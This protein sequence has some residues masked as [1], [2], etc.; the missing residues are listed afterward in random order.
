[1]SQSTKAI[2]GRFEVTQCLG[3]GMQGKVYLGRDPILDRQVALKLISPAGDDLAYSENV[4]SEARIAARIS[5][6]NVI[7][8][9]EVGLYESS[10]L[11][12]FEYI[13]GITLNNYI[14]KHGRFTEKSAIN[15]MHQIADGMKCAH[16][17]SIA[18]L[19][20][21]SNNIM[22][23]K[24]GIPRIMDF[25]LA[26]VIS[27]TDVIQNSKIAMGTPRYMAPENLTGRELTQA[28][29]I[30]TLGLLFYELLT[31]TPAFNYKNMNDIIVATKNVK[32]DWGKL[33]HLA[34]SNEVIAILRDMLQLEPA[35]RY[36]SAST[37][38]SEL[39]ELIAMQ[40]HEDRGSVSLNFLLRRLQRRPEFPACSHS[41][42]EINRLT[43]ESSNTNFNQLGAV[44][45]RDYSLTN[46]I[47]K[48]ANS[49]IFDRGN[50]GVKTISQAISRLGLKLVR[51]ICNG[52]LLFNQADNKDN[53]L[54]D[55]LVASFVAGLISRHITAIKNKRLAEEAFICG[56]FHNLGN[57]LLIF[58]LPDEYD[59]IKTLIK[60]GEEAQQAERNVL[61]TTT[62]SL[63][64]AVA[65]KW[66]FPETIINCMKRLPQG[67]L[68]PPNNDNNILSH[69]ANYAN[70]LCSLIMSDTQN[71]ELIV[72]ISDFN[73][74]HQNLFK[75]DVANL[76]K[77]VASAADKFSTLAP[78]LG[79]NFN[80]SDFCQQL[81]QFSVKIETIQQQVDMEVT[82]I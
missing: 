31:G 45:I 4:I 26:H 79:V 55:V 32:I 81:S 22:M 17:Q 9:Y 78:G 14:H 25:G 13:D 21:S 53:D 50:E 70:E 30:F 57:H 33:Q 29:D 41:I 63:G 73:D 3:K 35:N 38:I 66:N 65:E 18:H 62:A 76:G 47:M 16:E 43:D 67:L 42:A 61:S 64:M 56:M 51:M 71:M 60:E 7:P 20:L 69:A 48:I 27:A 10:P 46:R 49:V 24:A 82:L 8:I 2:I 75:C 74:R 77:L 12:V 28:T 6:P 52:L 68:A 11:L 40:D 36:Q 19:D 15:L 59:E 34:I 44:I 5:H 23:D 39:D 1:M 54:K 58:Y 80:E 72:K 37:L